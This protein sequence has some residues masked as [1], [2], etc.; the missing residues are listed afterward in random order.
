MP[1]ATVSPGLIDRAEEAGRGI[2]LRTPVMP[3]AAL[4]ERCGGVIVLK[5]EN[6]QRTGSFKIRGAMSKLAALGSA[7]AKGV[8]AGSAGNHA[9]AVAFA[10]RHAGVPCEIFVPAGAPLSKI[11]ACRAYGAVLVE[12]GDS[13]DEAVAAARQR[14]AEAGMVF[15]HP[16]DDLEVIAGQATLGRELIVEVPRLRRVIVPLGGGGLAS[17]I[18]M[19]VKGS[20]SGIEV[21]GVQVEACAPYAHR[22]P[23]S[24]P[25]VTLADGI[26]VK[27][28]GEITRPLVER[29]LDDVVVVDENTVADAMVLLLE[30]AKLSVEG[31]GAVGVAALIANTVTPAENGTT[32]VVLSGGNVD[33]GLLPGLIRRHETQAGRR[34]ILFAR[35]SDRPGGLAGLL[36]L[37]AEHGANLIEV[38]HVR[39]GVDLHVRETGVQLVLEVR[40]RGHADSVVRAAIDAGYPIEVI[41]Q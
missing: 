11:E 21:I 35:I 13:L 23:P 33:L 12:G 6:L 28:P 3:S 18:A 24:G 19:T 31:A 5:A 16:Y 30:R 9:Q 34:L 1:A 27:R 32:C 4:T 7:A 41:S 29:W 15:C 38:E 25:I 14:A 20:D 8:T 10:A 40:G 37:F 26:A 17:G 39:E 22:A 36:N 2:V